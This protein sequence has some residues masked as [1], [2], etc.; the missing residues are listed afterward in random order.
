MERSQGKP[1]KEEM[2]E[3][4]DGKRVKLVKPGKSN[5]GV[6]HGWRRAL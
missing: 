4:R 6:I 5:L 1:I 2:K 3:K